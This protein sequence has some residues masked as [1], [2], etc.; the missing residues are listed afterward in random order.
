MKT[1]NARQQK[2]LS[3]NF[4][5]GDFSVSE[6]T[7]YLDLDV[8]LVTLRRDI[9]ELVDIRYLAERGK[10]RSLRY[11]KTILGTLLTPFDAH[12]YQYQDLD[13]RVVTPRFNELL[14]VHFPASVFSPTELKTLENATHTYQ[15]KHTH[16]TPTI[17]EKELER[18][19]IE[20]SWKSSS[21]EGNTYTLLD[22]ELLLR[23]G[24]TAEGKTPDE[25]TMILNHKKAFS[26]VMEYKDQMKKKIPHSFVEE[27]HN[28]LVDGL[29]VDT[30]I[31]KSGVGIT[32]TSYTPLETD[33]QIKE[34]LE[35]LFVAIDRSSSVYQKA[36]L[37]LVG[38]SYIQ[39]FADGNK[40]TARLLANA[41]LLSE[42]AAPLS[43]RN[44]D[45]KYYRE[46]ILVFYEQNSILPMKD[47][48]IDQYL[49]ATEHYA[50]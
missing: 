14:F 34:A 22:T 43:Y 8:S 38:I 20:L 36:L 17:K 42:N 13:T 18:F 46:A 24:I 44:V 4:T 25:T 39:P 41:L 37:A 49:F 23:D 11:Y 19:I 27:L 12:Q 29:G 50:V 9:R 21:I 47:I 15:Q 3:H 2:I 5:L 35:Q 7:D 26:F 48:F 6:V 1:L 28:I 33:F 45:I 32:G 30:G 40:R 31:R 10:G 16:Q